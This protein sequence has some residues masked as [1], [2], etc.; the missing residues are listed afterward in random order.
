MA[1]TIY[2]LVGLFLPSSRR[3]I[4]G[5]D[6]HTGAVRT[7]GSYVTFLPPHR[8]YRLSFEKREGAAQ[9]DGVIRITSKEGVPVTVTYRL[10]FSIV[11]SQLADSR[12][13]VTDGWSAWIRAR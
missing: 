10:R 7:V 6:K 8:Y 9:R 13:L 4:F 12:R 11:G 3:L 5:V 2:L 1:G